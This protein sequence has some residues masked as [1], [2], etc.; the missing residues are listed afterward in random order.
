MYSS[1]GATSV[2]ASLWSV[3]D[4]S[5]KEFMIHFYTELAAGQSKV[6]SLQ[7]AQITLMKNPRFSHPLYWAP[8]ASPIC[9]EATR[10]LPAPNR[11]CPESVIVAI[12]KKL[13]RP[14]FVRVLGVLCAMICKFERLMH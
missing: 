5:T 8:G 6:A 7:S 13:G 4:E 12:A 2:L 3:D 11:T 9:V 10:V 1:A 14:H